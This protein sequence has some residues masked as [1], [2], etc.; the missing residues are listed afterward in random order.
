MRSWDTASRM[1]EKLGYSGKKLAFYSY[2]KVKCSYTAWEEPK[3]CYM[4][5]KVSRTIACR[6]QTICTFT[7]TAG[8]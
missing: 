6:M 3:N 8:T 5:K 7:F 4:H 1:D 2:N